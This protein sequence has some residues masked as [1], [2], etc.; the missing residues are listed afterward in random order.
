MRG[1]REQ[2]R[3]HEEAMRRHHK[4]IEESFKFD[5]NDLFDDNSFDSFFGGKVDGGD[6]SYANSRILKQTSEAAAI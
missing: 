2:M 4:I 6:Y 5:F 3:A 1:H